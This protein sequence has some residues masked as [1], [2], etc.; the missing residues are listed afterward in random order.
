MDFSE[1]KM[2]WWLI[3]LIGAIIV[4]VSIFLLADRSA[5]LV[6]LTWIVALGAAATGI[7]YL[8]MALRQNGPNGT[9]IP[10]L[11]H[12]LID[13]LLVLLI[14]VI[15][16]SQALLGII[17]A[18]WLIVFGVF[19]ILSCRQRD[20]TRLSRLG[21]LLAL[22]G[23]ALLIIPLA[24]RIDYVILIAIAGLVFGI[25]RIVLGILIKVKHDQRTSDGRSNLL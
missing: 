25:V 17:I 15:P 3:I 11:I 4:V 6:L 22:I 18:C 9:S 5:G 24:L 10:L 20:K 12:G 14:I 7:F 23:L 1:R 16:N 2:P 13:M 21:V 19:E 8:V